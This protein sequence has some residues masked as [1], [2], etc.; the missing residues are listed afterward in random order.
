MTT[1]KSIGIKAV[2][3]SL[4]LMGMALS[5]V[6]AQAQ[7]SQEQVSQL[8]VAIFGRAS[9]GEGN[10]FWQTYQPDIISTANAML[11]TEAAQ[12]YFG[13]SLNSNQAFIE[14][15]YLLTLNKTNTDDPNGVAYWVGE[16]GKGKSRGEVVATLVGVIK[17]YAPGGLYYNPNDE[18]TIAA[19]NQFTNRVTVC[20]YMADT[21][22]PLPA[23]WATATQFGP[24]GLNVTF[25]GATVAAARNKINNFSSG[26]GG[27]DLEDDI[28]YYMAII[29]SAGDMTPMIEGITAL[30]MAVMNGDTS[31]VT[32]NPPMET[33]DLNNLPSTITM[34]ANFGTGYT[35]EGSTSVFTGQAVIQITNL[36]LNQQTGAISANAALTATNVRQ[37]GQ[38]L[39]NGAM[40]LGVNVAMLGDN[41]LS[42]TA[43]MTFI[44]LE[45]LNFK[46]NG[47]I[48]LS[49]PPM[50]L[51]GGQL[52]QPIVLTFNQFTTQDFQISGTVTI[53]QIGADSINAL[54]DLDTNQGEMNGLI[55]ING[56]N[57]DQATISTPSGPLTAGGYSVTINNVVMDAAV[58]QD[59]PYSGNIVITG[60]SETKTITYSNCAYTV[61]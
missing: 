40:T 32:I 60:D 59:M 17:E 25:D 55:R 51:S 9:E 54:F 58:C 13:S 46:A 16:L 22:Y 31:V 48:G 35:P 4:I 42:A 12:N 47:G 1:M 8:Y 6:P 27:G 38:L 44:N 7:L 14:H 24:G 39:L 34:T 41:T 10:T 20:N 61:N 2:A 33:L 52:T 57:G 43:N 19:Y 30:F 3:I 50:N 36:I 28:E 56:I 53:S 5:S 45:S 29:S 23:N 21:I 11:A 26:N 18:K 15:I 49:I 37:D